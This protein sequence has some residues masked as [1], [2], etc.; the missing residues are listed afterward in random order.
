[1]EYRKRMRGLAAG[2]VMVAIPLPLMA[3]TAH[4]QGAAS[5]PSQRSA[6]HAARHATPPPAAV[7]LYMAPQPPLDPADSF[8]LYVGEA[9][10][11]KLPASIV[12]T[13]VG[14]G[15]VL[16]VAALENNEMLLIASDAGRSTLHLWLGDGSEVS[17]A[18]EV[19]ADSPTKMYAQVKEAFGNEKG[20]HVSLVGNRVFLR[21]ETLTPGQ[22]NLVKA[23][24]QAFGDKII[25]ITE[26]DV[27]LEERTVHVNAQLVEIKKSALEQL[28][29]KWSESIQGPSLAIVGDAAHWYLR[30]GSDDVDW[31]GY[32]PPFRSAFSLATLIT[33]R[34]NLLRSQGDAYVVAEPRLTARCGGKADFTS[35]GELPIPVQTGLG[36]TNVEFKKY[37]VRLSIE[38]QCDRLGNI[39]AKVAVE[40]S[41]IDNAVAVMGVPGLLTRQAESELDLVN[42]KSM[43]LSGLASYEAGKSEDKVPFFGSIPLLG[44]LFK[45]TDTDGGRSELV[46]IITPSFVT[47]ESETIQER[48]KR[49]EQL[50]GETE[51][52]LLDQGLT[53]LD[54]KPA[55]QAEENPSNQGSATPEAKQ[56]E[57]ATQVELV[58]N[59]EESQ[60]DQ[61]LTPEAKQEEPATQV[62]LAGKAEESQP[63]Q[64][65]TLETKQEE[66]AAQIELV[67]KAEESQ[68]DQ[69]LTLEAKQEEPAT[70]V[71]LAG[72]A[73][74]SQPD[75]ELT[76]ETKQEEP[77]TGVELVGKAEE[78]QPN[79]ELTPEAKQE[80]PA[81][82]VELVGKAE[83]SQPNQELTLE[84]KQEEPATQVELVGKA[85][86]S[87]P[88]Q[89]LTL[90]AKQEEPAT[91][92][93][94]VGKAEESQPDQE[95]TLETK[96]EEPATG[97][98]LAGKVEESPLDAIGGEAAKAEVVS[99]QPTAR[100]DALP[101]PIIVYSV[102]GDVPWRP[103]NVHSDGQKTVIEMPRGIP[104][105]N[106]P[107]LLVMQDAVDAAPVRY[108]LEDSRYVVDAVLERAML[109]AGAGFYRES[110]MI[111]RQP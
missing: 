41:Q 107:I 29:V 37:G 27:A 66:P 35:G 13:A 32:T 98:E 24:Q 36:A 46:V 39:R 58:G 108:R 11:I 2:L 20:V 10:V 48:V 31:P 71:E 8:H 90:E 42:G 47:S 64:E 68:P 80:E 61:G 105:K 89:E 33:S 60:P 93:E 83:E 26:G 77:A 6:R 53:P 40:V 57:P 5:P 59:A 109:V 100:D 85:E 88:D 65:L 23:L 75:Q 7:Q 74:E 38:P 30:Q 110:A 14:N 87:Q 3:Q 78:S 102:T 91:G 21:A 43:L 62:E 81:T 70:Q 99:A 50:T 56:E 103:A 111:A 28:G 16:A 15:K 1:M 101:R 4:Q 79:Q 19:A 63:D 55:D 73:E 45:S 97:V 22:V 94:L 52:N 84:T 96:Q 34:I 69:G 86:G 49:S 12:K 92:V 51:E 18:V 72:K 106:A 25:L 44:H 76:L 9:R 67:G 82:Q 104:V 54:A 95:L 17:Y